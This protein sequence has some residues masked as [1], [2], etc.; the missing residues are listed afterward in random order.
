MAAKNLTVKKSLGFIDGIA[1]FVANNNN[2]KKAN[3]CLK[4]QLIV[5]TMA[6][7]FLS[8]TP[9]LAYFLAINEDFTIIIVYLMISSPT[10]LIA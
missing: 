10:Y 4:L 8:L 3:Y 7:T 1:T 9:I 5:V 6:F 2:N